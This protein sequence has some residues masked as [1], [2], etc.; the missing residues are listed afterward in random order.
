MAQTSN[1][2]ISFQWHITDICN[3][4][5]KHCYQ[6]N[7]TSESDLP[8]GKMK[9]ILENLSSQFKRISINITGGEPFFKKDF[10][11]FLDIVSEF[12]NI[13]SFSIITNGTLLNDHNIS[14]LKNY[15][16]LGTLKISIDG[17]QSNDIIRG[18]GI[19]KIVAK[20][21]M[22]IKDLKKII[23][24]TAGS[25]NYL[26]INDVFQFSKEVAD[27]I[28]IERFVPLGIGKELIGFYIKKEEWRY[29]ANFIKDYFSIDDINE[30]SKYKA[31]YIDFKNEKLFGALCNLGESFAIMPDGTIYP[32]RRL[33][34][35][36]GN[37]LFERDIIGKIKDFRRMLEKNLDDKCK[38]CKYFNE[39]IGCRAGV[40]ATKNNLFYP[41]EQ[42]FL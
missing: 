9:E 4:R 22:R 16:K 37:A 5:C 25:Y 28:I 1:D 24:F 33:P 31:F 6:E 38:T 42:C 30:I 12:K 3:L 39:C 36:I 29:I 40:Y 11:E 23:M 41:D 32:C 19:L 35:S 34:I 26:D 17:I 21:M 2:F 7:F 10:F 18:S 14:L 15:S 13:D 20:N 27:G 8:L